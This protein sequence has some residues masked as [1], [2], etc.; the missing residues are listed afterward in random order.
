MSSPRRIG[1]LLYKKSRNELNAG[2]EKE[3]NAW[4][5]ESP[6]N[7]Q[8]FLDKMDPEKVRSSMIRLYE[9]RDLIFEKIKAI[10]PELANEKLSNQDFSDPDFHESTQER[11]YFRMV[12]SSRVARFGC[13][14]VISA[15]LYLF[16]RLTGVIHKTVRANPDA[17]G[18]SP[19]G[20][21]VQIDGGS[22]GYRAARARIDLEDNKLC[23]KDYYAT[24][25]DKDRRMRYSLPTGDVR[26]FRLILPDSTWI[27]VH[28][29][30]RI[31]YP[32]NF[33]QDT[34]HVTVLGKA[35][36]EVNKDSHHPYIIIQ[37]AIV[38][39]LSSG[40]LTIEAVTSHFDIEAYPD[41]SAMRVT[42]IT[43]NIFVRRD[44]V[45]GKPRE[46]FR[47]SAGQQL[48][49]KNDS[50]RII[51]HVDVNQ[52]LTRTKWYAGK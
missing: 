34:I 46:E 16:L 31:K 2:E 13:L 50:M 27:W 35:Y 40:P 30:T 5:K 17:V 36:F 25:R 44:S 45:A 3:L 18:V 19:E 6:E 14:I 24:S 9:E 23:E 11:K 28:A 1:N 22:V 21:E 26:H 43:G 20:L 12:P 48:E 4:R 51:E 29:N 7:E 49:T 32:V 52:I 41:S 8:L 39:H 42:V 38:S 33:S 47:L 10:I 15:V 37:P